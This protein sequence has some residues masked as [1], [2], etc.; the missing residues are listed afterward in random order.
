MIQQ[1]GM[2]R[3]GPARNSAAGPVAAC[4]SCVGCVLCTFGVF[5][6]V[7]GIALYASSQDSNFQDDF[8]EDTNKYVYSGLCKKMIMGYNP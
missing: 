2:I 1:G 4:L 6:L 8:F 7:P 5:L 3:I